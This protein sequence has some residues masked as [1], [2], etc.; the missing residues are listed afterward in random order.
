[1]KEA[2]V[3]FKDNNFTESVKVA[4]FHTGFRELEQ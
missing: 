2:K 3:G 4:S 1:V